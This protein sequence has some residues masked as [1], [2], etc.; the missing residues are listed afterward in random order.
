M[1]VIAAGLLPGCASGPP[2]EPIKVVTVASAEPDVNKPLPTPSPLDNAGP[3]FDDVAILHQPLPEGPAFISAYNKVGKPRLMIFVNRTLTGDLIPV[4]PV[5]PDV[6][7]QHTEQTTGAV[8]IN[9]NTTSLDA[10]Y[11]SWLVQNNYRSFET[12][13]PAQYTNKTEVYLKP[14]QYDEAQAKSIDYELIENLI[15]DNLSVD[16]Q[17]MLI[18]PIASRQRLTDTEIKEL[19]EGRPQ[20]LG[21]IAEKLQCDVLIQVTAHPSQ[22]TSDGLGIRLIAEA[23]NTKGG[24]EIG[25]AAVDISPPLVKTK[26]NA[27]TRFVSRKLM[28]GM[29]RVWTTMAAQAPPPLPATVKPADALPPGAQGNSSPTTKTS[30]NLS[31]P[32]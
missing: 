19:Q 5:E 4:N 20:M 1:G 10:G 21:E 32:P 6:S 14:S 17:V 25:N 3:G 28:D 24:Q 2:P 18:S 8:K 29:T 26:L 12:S 22:Q 13:G 30:T 16:G 7:I 11:Y 9:S 23:F 15:T 27:N 31:D